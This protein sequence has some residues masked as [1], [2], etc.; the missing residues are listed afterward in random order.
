[1]FR[2]PAKLAATINAVIF[3]AEKCMVQEFYSC[4]LVSIAIVFSA[5]R[6][7]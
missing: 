2:P 5:A 3:A 6:L 7:A 4:T 1:M